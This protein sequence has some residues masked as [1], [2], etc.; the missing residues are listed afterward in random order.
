MLTEALPKGLREW[1]YA[2]AAAAG[3]ALVLAL[4]ASAG[5]V[6]G[7]V[8]AGSALEAPAAEVKP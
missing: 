1:L 3:V 7:P 2:A 6:A 4:T 5:T 8:G